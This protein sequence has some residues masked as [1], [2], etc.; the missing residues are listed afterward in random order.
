VAT[1]DPAPPA[2]LWLLK[3][4]FGLAILV[5][6]GTAGLL[7]AERIDAARWA[8]VTI[9]TVGLYM[10]GEAGGAMAAS[11]KRGS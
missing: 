4:Q 8:D 9:W 7:L 10:L 11:W 1:P 3:R 5:L 6:V 2:E